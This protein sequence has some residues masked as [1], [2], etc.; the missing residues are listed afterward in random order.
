[1]GVGEEGRREIKRESAQGGTGRRERREN[2]EKPRHVLSVCLHT[3]RE[4]PGGD[5]VNEK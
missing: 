2:S 3:V 1:M 4:G 5:C